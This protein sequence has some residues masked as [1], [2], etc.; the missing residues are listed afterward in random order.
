[1]AIIDAVRIR[2][3]LFSHLKANWSYVK[4]CDILRINRSVLRHHYIKKE[5][6]CIKL[7]ILLLHISIHLCRN[8]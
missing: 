1:M 6:F 8:I 4:V 3:L 5:I 7:V 2:N